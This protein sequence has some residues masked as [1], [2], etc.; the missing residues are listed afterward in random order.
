MKCQITESP[1]FGSVRSGSDMSWF[2]FRRFQFQN[3]V[4]PVP[5]RASPP[6]PKRSGIS[7]DSEASPLGPK[8]PGRYFLDPKNS[9]KTLP[10]LPKLKT[11]KTRTN[12]PF[13]ELALKPSYSSHRKDANSQILAPKGPNRAK[14]E[15]SG[16]NVRVK[17]QFR[18]FWFHSV[19]VPPVPFGHLVPSSSGFKSSG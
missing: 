10:K 18:W 6:I 11:S 14:I 2:W 5:V 17:I 13:Q 19:L 9:P 16:P 1:R 12:E 7:S 4:P 8:H 3:P 15:F